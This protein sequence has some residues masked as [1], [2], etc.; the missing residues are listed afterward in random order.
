VGLGSMI[1]CDG[2][3]EQGR[4]ALLLELEELPGVFD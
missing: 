4:E 1:A 2:L 3:L